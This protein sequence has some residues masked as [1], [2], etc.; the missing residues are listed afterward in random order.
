MLRWYVYTLSQHSSNYT[1]ILLL[2]ICQFL[3][4]IKTPCFFFKCYIFD[5]RIDK[6]PSVPVFLNSVVLIIVAF[7]FFQIFLFLHYL[8]IYFFLSDR[9]LPFSPSWSGTYYVAQ[10]VFKLTSISLPEP[11]EC[12]D[13]QH[14]LLLP[15]SHGHFKGVTMALLLLYQEIFSASQQFL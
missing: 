14:I 3:K 13:C 4:W 5:D 11:P 9:V 15:A 1:Q 2:K 8:F 6:P 12:W 7:P 10:S